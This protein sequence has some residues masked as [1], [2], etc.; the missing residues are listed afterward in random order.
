MGFEIGYD[1]CDLVLTLDQIRSRL[2]LERIFEIFGGCTVWLT[3]PS[4]RVRSNALYNVGFEFAVVYQIYREVKVLFMV[5]AG[6]FQTSST[7]FA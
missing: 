4:L 2:N 1:L 3:W 7:E 6:K 5:C